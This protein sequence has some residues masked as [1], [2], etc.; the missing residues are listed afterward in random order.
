MAQEVE[1]FGIKTTLV[2]PGFFRTGLLA[3]QSVVF[4]EVAVDGYDAP[5]AVKAR[6]QGYHGNQGGDPAK[7]GQALVRIAAMDSPP[8]QF[9]AGSDAV[10][11]VTADLRA[12]LAEVEAHHALSVSTDGNF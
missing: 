1:R 7:L 3:P 10:Q 5:A 9:F 12:R 4:G 8:R 2:E 6:W 11:G